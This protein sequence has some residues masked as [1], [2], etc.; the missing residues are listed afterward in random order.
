MVNARGGGGLEACSP[1]NILRLPE[2][3]SG[4]FSDILLRMHKQ[5]CHF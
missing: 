1:R 5:D 3:T 2:I 4:E